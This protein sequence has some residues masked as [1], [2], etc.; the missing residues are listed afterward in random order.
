[1]SSAKKTARKM[2]LQALRE[3]D[4]KQ[5]ERESQAVCNAVW[6]RVL[7]PAAARLAASSRTTTTT[8]NIDGGRLAV[9]TYLPMSYELSLLPLMERVW[10]R[11]PAASANESLPQDL[12]HHDHDDDG[13]SRTVRIETFVPHMV[14]AEPT[15]RTPLPPSTD[16]VASPPVTAYC[17]SSPPPPSLVTEPSTTSTVSS[18]TSTTSG[19]GGEMM[20]VQVRSI[21]DL[22]GCFTPRGK[23]NILELT[24]EAERELMTAV[25]DDAARLLVTSPLVH[26]DGEHHCDPHDKNQNVTKRGY[27]CFG[28]TAKLIPPPVQTLY[29]SRTTITLP[30]PPLSLRSDG[31]Q[32]TP[33]IDSGY[34]RTPQ[35]S[36]TF[37]NVSSGVIV[38]EGSTTSMPPHCVDSIIS[39]PEDQQ[40]TPAQPPPPLEPDVKA[41]VVNATV[42]VPL[43]QHNDAPPPTTLVI[44]TPAALYDAL[45]GRLGKGG[46]FYDLFLRRASALRGGCGSFYEILVVGVGLSPQLLGGAFAATNFA[47]IAPFT[48]ISSPSTVQ[49]PSSC[50]LTVTTA[51]PPEDRNSDDNS[52][53]A[54]TK[55]EVS[56]EACSVPTPQPTTLLPF[57]TPA[58]VIHIIPS[59]DAQELKKAVVDAPLAIDRVP[60]DPWDE[61]VDELIIAC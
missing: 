23:M 51:P 43:Q 18:T 35:S 57:E 26:D 39:H 37:S 8:K 60:M 58:K 13:I 25:L 31:G 47:A 6:N 53:T 12:E 27:L 56:Y 54:E 1:M 34:L 48:I 4:P 9:L 30:K 41:T 50:T 20:F 14:K 32:A 28:T 49:P 10:A 44:L 45:G 22:Q 19:K 11:D 24:E 36:H 59:I 2:A 16:A 5:R 21:N 42:D 38:A 61:F 46:G 29:N 15:P 33:L 40:Q 17:S 55:D 52:N 7:I 3:M